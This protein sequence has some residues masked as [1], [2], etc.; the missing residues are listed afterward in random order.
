MDTYTPLQK[1]LV[2]QPISVDCFTVT[3]EQI[4]GVLGLSLP[5][6]ARNNPTWWTNNP[7]RHS[8]AKAWLDAGF[9]TEQVNI[10]DE[11]L[12]FRRA[13]FREEISN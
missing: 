12:V 9:L 2:V 6:T 3:F 1:W 8:Q 4:E 5:P 10:A 13:V 7:N 11:T